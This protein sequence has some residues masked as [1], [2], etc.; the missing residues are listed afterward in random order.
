[1]ARA[2]RS[3]AGGSEP[4]SVSNLKVKLRLRSDNARHEVVCIELPYR[5]SELY[6]DT[7]SFASTAPATQ[8]I[9]PYTAHCVHSAISDHAQGSE[10]VRSIT[11]LSNGTRSLG[12]TRCSISTQVLAS[13]VRLTPGATTL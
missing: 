9:I 12:V 7:T 3:D 13:L 2:G 11:A 6:M 5:S 4:R 10:D 8:P 1:M